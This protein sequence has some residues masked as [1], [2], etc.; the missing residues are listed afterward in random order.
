MQKITTF[1]D[2]RFLFVCL[3]LFV[4][5]S[6]KK[7]QA[8]CP[9]MTIAVTS[10]SCPSA[11]NGQIAVTLSNVT[12]L[13]NV[14]LYI[15]V[16]GTGLVPVAN[17]LNQ[18]TN[19]FTFTG[20]APS[21]RYVVIVSF[22]TSNPV[23]V[24]CGSILASAPI[25]VNNPS[26][27]FNPTPAPNICQIAA[28][29]TIIATY[30]GS[31]LGTGTFTGTGISASGVFNPT[32][33]GV[34]THTITYTYVTASCTIVGTQNITVTATPVLSFTISPST[35][36]RAGGL[37]PLTATP[38][39]GTFSGLGVTGTNLDPNVGAN[40]VRTITYT[41]TQNGCTRTATSTI[42]VVAN[43]TVSLSGLLPI[44]CTNAPSATATVSPAGGT[45]SGAGVS[46]LT[47]N[48]ATA[49][50][51][52]HTLTYTFLQN[53][54]T[55][56][57][58][59]VVE[60]RNPTVVVSFTN[61]SP[62]YCVNAVPFGLTA[63]LNGG[64]FSGNGVVG[65]VFTP[66]NAG[67]GTHIISYAY[68]DAGCAGII[69]Q[70]VQVVAPVV[71]SFSGLPVV[72]PVS[73]CK[74]APA[75]TL[76]GTPAGGTFSGNGISGNSF[77]P[78]NASVNIGVNAITYTVT[79][80]NCTVSST[81]NVII[82]A[83]PTIIFGGLNANYCLASPNTT[84]AATPT[85]GSF[86][87]NGISGNVFSASSAG[88]GIH[89]ITYSFTNN[90]CTTIGTQNVEVIA[91]PTVSIVGLSSPYCLSSG[92]VNLASTPAGGTF[93]GTGVSGTVGNYVFNPTTAGIGFHTIDYVV[94]LGGCS[95]NTSQV[96]EVKTGT[97]TPTI[98]GLGTNYCLLAPSINLTGTPAGGT[99][100]GVGMSGNTFNPSVAGVGT[101]T[102]TYNFNSG[103]CT[104]SAIQTV[105]VTPTPIIVFPNTIPTSICVSGANIALSATPAGGV[106]SGT[107]VSGTVGN[108]IFSPA[109]AGIGTFPVVYTFSENG[110]TVTNNININVTPTP[111]LVFGALPTQYC[112]SATNLILTATPVG[113]VFSGTG[114]ALSGADYVFSPTI[115][116]IGTH[117]LTY[118][119]IQ[120]GCT[121]TTT[122]SIT[123][124]PTPVVSISG[125]LANYCNDIIGVPLVGVPASTATQGVF[126]GTGVSGTAGN[127]IFNPNAAG[128]GIKTIT[129][130]YVDNGCTVSVTQ[131]TTVAFCDPCAGVTISATLTLTQPTTCGQTGTIVVSAPAGGTAPYTYSLNSAPFVST[132]TFNNLAPNTYTLIVKDAIGC[133]QTYSSIINPYVGISVTSI[134]QT[135]VSCAGGNNGTI[136]VVATGGNGNYEYSLDGTIFQPLNTFTGLIAG[137]YTVSIKDNLA[138]V[139]TANISVIQ[140]STLSA[141]AVV[142]NPSNCVLSNG[143]I[144]F[145]NVVG[146]NAPYQYSINNGANYVST[147]TFTNVAAG[148]YIVSVIDAKSCVWSNTIVLG[149]TNNLAGSVITFPASCGGTNGQV[150]AQN[151][152]GGGGTYVYSLDNMN[153]QSNPLFMNLAAG[154]YTLYVKDP[155]SL[156]FA[157]VPALVGSTSGFT[158][159]LSNVQPTSC[160]VGNGSITVSSPSGG[161]AP[162]Q[163]SLDGIT[164]QNSPVF[165]GLSGGNYNI[166]IKDS[167]NC[168]LILPTA[169]TGSTS[170]IIIGAPSGVSPSC[171]GLLNGQV[172]ITSVTGGV[173]PYQYSLDN[174]TFQSSPIFTGLAD[175]FYTIYV[176][177]A[178]NCVQNTTYTLLPT[179]TI[180]F[181][182][183]QVGLANCSNPTARVE[184]R[185]VVG[186]LAPYQY[187]MDGVNYT[188]S[189][190]FEN[191][192]AGT[193]TCY[194][195]DSRVGN[196]VTQRSAIVDGTKAFNYI[197]TQQ[198]LDCKQGLG[199][200]KI[201]AIVGG[202]L[203]YV[204]TLKKDNQI[205]K[206]ETIFVD[207][208]T[209]TDLLEGNY[210]LN[211]TNASTCSIADKTIILKK[212][213]PLAATISTTK[214]LLTEPTGSIL[215]EE[216]TGGT[217]PYS[218]SIDSA[219]TF[220]I[221]N[222]NFLTVNNLAVGEYVVVVRDVVGCEFR[223]K[224][225]IEESLFAIPNVFTPN[226]DGKNETFFVENLPKEG[227]YL[228]VS[229]RWGKTVF[230]TSNY[231]ND[232]KAEGLSE[233][234]YF[235]ILQIPNK[236]AVTGNVQIW[237]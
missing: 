177:D 122:K 221:L 185:N 63:S 46:G 208:Y 190:V 155:I 71:V 87:G 11:N 28:P 94:V 62:A 8:Q 17:F 39:G 43:T 174:V 109:T 226:N 105:N 151:A 60:V 168:S 95:F 206:T 107:G 86:S 228:R 53:N 37:V 171:A 196:C 102:I 188:S 235:Y 148:T 29:R 113:G 52:F 20:L 101:H 70:S 18:T 83:P 157:T 162:Y 90:G 104:S 161:V 207:N 111:V 119:F 200:I 236:E 201:T 212:S 232:W 216:I 156:C 13:F 124:T 176:K 32:T 181:D 198:N 10:P 100:V 154:N 38:T 23:P 220:K 33:A 21:D 35:I 178:S 68:N 69:T 194:V 82:T 170:P 139:T 145:S 191:V 56:T 19:P 44:Y 131:N 41:F 164:Y 77:D 140:P 115:A 114:V 75:L 116:T 80:N 64:T 57:A 58:T 193:Y 169:L 61:L 66:T 50:V 110:C 99:F 79:Q 65:N 5:F 121:L 150:L 153:Y 205:I 199:N 59:R 230:E 146:G 160:G 85:G 6:T 93:S 187:S 180:T 49:G 103:G 54:C 224:V 92:T 186:G 138:C 197:L 31:A 98:A 73:Y 195:K 204:L 76:T 135:P 192:A 189:N 144:T 152:I 133:S 184:V 127:Y 84:I 51:G 136:T 149:F 30:T 129:Y 117:I 34:G 203:P 213:I 26:I 215:I 134:I 22:P 72:A 88:V 125:L 163:Y 234:V 106:F 233:G 137:S 173:L 132:T 48:P 165:A 219:K 7:L 42:N 130:T 179:N 229:N 9:N 128:N 45:L 78:N 222:D 67:I 108:Y 142:T 12:G 237:R 218:V 81:Q 158:A 74:T 40:G 118:T 2:V 223:V 14:A 36:C 175:G 227:A 217:S 126:S 120:N 141:N 27:I 231:Q 16:V 112:L 183:V 182:F 211:V 25:V 55:F 96:V 159:N 24:G 3:L 1:I 89:T 166:H 47:F 167:N 209:F 91:N 123:I 202:T 147:A 225:I 214:S 97:V 172:S 143:I 210:T 15:D 4:G